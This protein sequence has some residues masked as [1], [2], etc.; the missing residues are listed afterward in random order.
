M[1]TLGNLNGLQIYQVT[2][3]RDGDFIQD[4]FKKKYQKLLERRL[5]QE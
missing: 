2:I 5:I 1:K 4:L 3:R